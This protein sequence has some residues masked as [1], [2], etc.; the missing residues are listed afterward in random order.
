MNESNGFGCAGGR[1]GARVAVAG[2][3]RKGGGYGGGFVTC[4]LF[5][6][7]KEEVKNRKGGKE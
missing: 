3:G 2:E 5:E 4:F 7:Q 6:E 1:E